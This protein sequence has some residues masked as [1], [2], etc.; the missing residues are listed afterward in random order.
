MK[1]AIYGGSFNPVHNEHKNTVINA[2][3]QF[4]IDK[5]FVVPSKIAPH[6]QDAKPIAFNHRFNMLKIAFEGEKNVEISDYENLNDGISYTYLTLQHFKSLYPEAE[7]FFMVGTDMLKDFPTWKNPGQILGVAT[8][9]VTKRD[10]DDF[11]DAQKFYYRHFDKKFLLSTYT[12]TSLSSSKIMN[13]LG[14]GLSV[15]EF[16]PEGVSE[17][18]KVNGLVKPDYLQEYVRNSLNEKRLRH[19]ANVMTLS[20]RYAK[21]L[22]VDVNLATLG[23]LLH[24]VAKYKDVTAY[25]D[26][27]LDHYVPPAVVHQYL[28][29]YVAEF[30]LGIKDCDVL[31]AI[32]YHTSGRKNMSKLEKIVFLADLL[33]EDRDFDGVDK[34]R[35]RVDEDF[36]KGF[37]FAVGELY[38]F[39]KQKNQDVY[40]LTEECLESLN[41]I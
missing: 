14:L 13:Y 40:S 23:A 36:E 12:G 17:Y 33:E 21:R 15:E 7:L 31:N 11:L 22:R 1:I 5:T 30:E 6:K 9:I 20:Q 26:F 8:L 38:R 39:L 41:N 29:A 19:T 32:R 28:G 18:I 27:T 25:P 2:M 37:K 34:I 35:R 4:G 10:G 16:L 24:D 3:R